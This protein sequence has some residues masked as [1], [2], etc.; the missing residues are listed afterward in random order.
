[1]HWSYVIVG[2]AIVGLGL[3]AYAANLIRTGR[4]LARQVPPDRRRFL[5]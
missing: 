4:R 5:D 3:A 1:M 2:Y